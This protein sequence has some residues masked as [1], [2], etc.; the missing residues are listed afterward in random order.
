MYL[1][2]RKLVTGSAGCVSLFFFS[3][4]SFIRRERSWLMRILTFFFLEC[5]SFYPYHDSLHP[6]PVDIGY[7]RFYVPSFG[8]LFR[9]MPFCRCIERLTTKK[10]TYVKQRHPLSR[11][12]FLLERYSWVITPVIWGV[13]ILH[14]GRT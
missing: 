10:K 5:T 14:A 9:V 6:T 4:I 3:F 12:T 11:V 8:G 2:D 7:G 1:A 13:S